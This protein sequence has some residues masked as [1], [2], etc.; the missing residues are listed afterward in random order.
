MSR[1][2]Q[3]FQ[4]SKVIWSKYQGVASQAALLDHLKMVTPLSFKSDLCT[5]TLRNNPN[6]LYRLFNWMADD[7]PA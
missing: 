1:A 5:R 6:K 3:I 4:L 7:H 2:N